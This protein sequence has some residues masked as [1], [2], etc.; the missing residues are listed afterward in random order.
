VHCA[1]G[2][3]TLPENE[4]GGPSPQRTLGPFPTTS[5]RV[6]HISLVFREM[7]DATAAGSEVLVCPGNSK[8]EICGIPHLAKNER[9]VGHPA[10]IAGT[11][12]DGEGRWR[13]AGSG[14]AK[15]AGCDSIRNQLPVDV[16]YGKG[17]A[18]T[19]GEIRRDGNGGDG[20]KALTIRA[21]WLAQCRR[22]VRGRVSHITH[23]AGM[24][25]M[26]A[27]ANGQ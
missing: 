9:D 17:E 10:V 4:T 27:A 12:L 15:Y 5:R 13:S 14:A 6:P 20:S 2:T 11:E 25:A 3:R 7:W 8:V 19:G 23:D 24:S 18:G 1:D 21:R 16:G 26:S 22:W